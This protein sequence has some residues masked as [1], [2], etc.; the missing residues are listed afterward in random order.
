N[1]VYLYYLPFPQYSGVSDTTS[2]VG[3][4]NWNALE[5]SLRQRPTHGFNFMLNYTYSKSIDDLGTF[6]VG[7]NDRLDRSLSTA[8]MPQNLVGTVVYQL[9]IGRGHMWG[10]NL[11][12][13]AIASDWTASG[14]FSDHSGFP[15]VLT[16]SGCGGAGILNQCMPSLV[17]G[18][19]G[20]QNGPYGKGTTAAPGSPKYIGAVQYINPAAFTVN[21]NSS[22]AS[23]QAINVGPGA[24]LYVPGNVPRVAALNLWG[25]GYYDADVAVKRTF[26]IYREWNI[27]IELDM[28]N[29]TNHVV[30]ASPSA[31]VASGTNAGFGTITALSSA[32]A[33]RDVQGSLR[34][35]F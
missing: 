27:G 24:A 34:I 4:E 26:P 6:R 10:D 5:I 18:Q 20:R 35:N 33:P 31:S 30:W 15:I 32:N 29:L 2:F 23:G 3:N 22:S 19:A 16:A 1:S 8:D 28:T 12:Y 17:A 14:I 11:I 7:D 13:R 9:P 25:M 21:V